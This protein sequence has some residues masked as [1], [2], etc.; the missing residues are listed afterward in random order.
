MMDV[1]LWG[2]SRGKISVMIK[3]RMQGHSFW[4]EGRFHGGFGDPGVVPER[5]VS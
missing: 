4:E 1:L 2:H 5:G 3:L